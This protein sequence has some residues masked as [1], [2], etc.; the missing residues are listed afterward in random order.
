M[1]DD[2][3]VFPKGSSLRPDWR[4][5][6][7]CASLLGCERMEHRCNPGSDS[8]T[9]VCTGPR[10]CNVSDCRGCHLAFHSACTQGRVADADKIRSGYNLNRN[11]CNFRRTDS[12][13]RG[14][15]CNWYSQ[16]R[17]CGRRNRIPDSYHSSG[18]GKG[19]QRI[20]CLHFQIPSWI[21]SCC[22]PEV[23]RLASW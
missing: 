13:A 10:I 3:N 9:C 2:N 17:P 1:H 12:F 20:D 11:S 18:W 16:G 22:H 7:S 6:N 21:R 23:L 4:G 14:T 5:G 19:W 15:P 8:W